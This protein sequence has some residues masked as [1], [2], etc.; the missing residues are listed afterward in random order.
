M[1]HL[2]DSMRE[3]PEFDPQYIIWSPKPCQACLLTVVMST[4]ATSTSGCGPKFTN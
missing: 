2:K 3:K 4:S 1:E